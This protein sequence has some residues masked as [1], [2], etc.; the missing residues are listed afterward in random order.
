MEIHRW[1]EE[2]Q[3]SN[4]YQH[5]IFLQGYDSVQFKTANSV[6]SKFL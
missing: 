3:D 1:P 4:K 6:L 2:H 5:D